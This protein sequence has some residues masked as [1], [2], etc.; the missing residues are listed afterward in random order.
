M[1]EGNSRYC[2]NSG[3]LGDFFVICWR[4][5]A[6]VSPPSRSR[7]TGVSERE[8]HT[9]SYLGH[10]KH[11]PLSIGGANNILLLVSASRF[12][13]THHHHRLRPPP[14]LCPSFFFS[15]VQEKQDERG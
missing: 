6:C 5:R 3:M 9:L 10:H 8:P 14:L 1:G 4:R 12:L 7:T 11:R 15:I 13:A 2:R